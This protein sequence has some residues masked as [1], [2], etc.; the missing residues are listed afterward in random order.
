MIVEITLGIVLA[1]IIF[2]LLPYIIYAGLYPFFKIYD[3]IV[4]LIK[5]CETYQN[6]RAV[7]NEGNA[8]VED[9]GSRLK[10]DEVERKNVEN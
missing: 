9:L 5:L 10:Q 7:V 2:K 8:A 4:W 1:V 6:K 3:C